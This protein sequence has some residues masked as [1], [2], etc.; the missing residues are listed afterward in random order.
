LCLCNYNNG[1]YT[2]LKPFLNIQEVTYK[3]NNICAGGYVI[4]KAFDSYQ[5]DEMLP[6]QIKTEN[7]TWHLGALSE[8][9][10]TYYRADSGLHNPVIVG[11]GVTKLEAKTNL[12][13]SLLKLDIITLK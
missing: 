6:N 11:K 8:T 13:I 12:L 2:Q 4:T 7:M 5:I 9:G 3:N 10:F 1:Q